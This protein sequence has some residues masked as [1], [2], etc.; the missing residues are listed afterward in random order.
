MLVGFGIAACVSSFCLIALAK[1]NIATLGAPMY[2]HVFAGR[3]LGFLIQPAAQILY[4]NIR[5]NVVFYPNSL[6]VI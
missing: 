3:K 1:Q 6:P 4:S 5:F 2:Q